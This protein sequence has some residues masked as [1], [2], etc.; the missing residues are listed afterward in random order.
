MKAIKNQILLA[1]LLL[2]FSSSISFGQS[3]EGKLTYIVAFEIETQNFGGI[4]ITKEQ[5]LEKTKADGE[6]FDTITITIKNGNYL[7]EDNALLNKKIIYKADENKVYTIEK[8]FEYVIISDANEISQVKLVKFQEPIFEQID[9]NAMINGIECKLIKLSWDGLGE[10]LYYY[11]SEV[12]SIDPKLFA[13]HNLEYFNTILNLTGSYPIET[14][15]TI[16]SF[17]SIKMTLVNISEEKIEDSVFDLPKLKKAKKDYS[18]M[19]LNITGAEVMKIK[20]K[21]KK[22]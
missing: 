10:E 6:F 15:K 13:K 21:A 20:G 8:D 2:T 17:M 18:E 7:K 11:N 5:I 14:I 1:L 22:K 19:L 3:F 9:T 12:I 4:E 16:S